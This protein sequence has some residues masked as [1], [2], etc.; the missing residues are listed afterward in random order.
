MPQGLLNPN[1][2]GSLCENKTLVGTFNLSTRFVKAICARLK[3]SNETDSNERN[4]ELD[5]HADTVCAGKEFVMFEKPDRYVDVHPYSEE[6][7]P[8]KDI[9]ITTA[10]TVWTSEIGDSYL[11]LFHEALFF[12]DRLDK[13]LICTNQLRAH[14]LIVEDV[15]R[16]FDRR[17]T[18]SI[19]IP[20]HEDLMIPL[21][22]N[23]IMS[24]FA[25][26][27][28]SPDELENLPRV[29]MTSSAPWKPHSESF[30]DAEENL[31]TVAGTMTICKVDPNCMAASAVQRMIAAAKSYR[32][33]MMNENL[34]IL[35][36][37]DEDD[38]YN[39][40]IKTVTVASD[41]MTGDG[42]TGHL[43]KDVYETSDEVKRIS[44]LSSGDR[45]STLTPELLAR[46]W[47]ISLP[48]AKQTLSVTTQAGVRN[49]LTPSERKV[50][51]KAPWLKFPNVKGRW[52][53]DLMKSTVPSIHGDNGATVYTNGQGYD[54]I[55]PWKTRGDHPDTLM[56]L[57]QD[58]G[59][60]QTLIS[61]GGKEL[62]YGRARDM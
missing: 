62:I 17:S 47:C 58:V 11:L 16:Q 10:A 19:R 41:D 51:K 26:H 37:G 53:C 23:G 13:S 56:S 21:E 18:H 43:D 35:R 4:C 44:A 42:L 33:S 38:F 55:Y 61:D 20:A 36:E 40:L 49:V 12:G 50:R 25:T 39:R 27:A 48:K 54:E 45:R 28:P 9:P 1:V 30:A 5:S 7:Q 29:T 15:P 14:G 46:R 31:R 24:C 6:Y 34:D 22:L 2:T 3:S 57:I 60:P 32:E 59:I 8:I 52:Y